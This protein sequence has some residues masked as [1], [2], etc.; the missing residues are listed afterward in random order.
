MTTKEKTHY[1][2]EW[3]K[4]TIENLIRLKLE[5]FRKQDPEDIYAIIE[6]E[7]LPYENFAQLV[8]EG[9]VIY[10][11]RKENYLMSAQIVVETMYPDQ[12]ENFKRRVRK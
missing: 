10:I 12:V 6:K 5:R 2:R 1:P 11:G 7:H 8:E 9:L 4:K 3:N